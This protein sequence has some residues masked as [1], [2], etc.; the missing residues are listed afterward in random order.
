MGTAFGLGWPGSFAGQTTPWGLVPPGGQG[1]GNYSTNPQSFVQPLQQV[2]QSLYNVTYQL[3]QQLQLQT[4]QQYQIQQLL[5]LIPTQL[6][7]LI[8]LLPQQIQ[9]LPQGQLQPF[10]QATPGAPMWPGT[11]A[12][13][14]G[15]FPQFSLFNRPLGGAASSFTSPPFAPGTPAGMAAGAQSPQIGSAPPTEAFGFGTGPLSFAQPPSVLG[16]SV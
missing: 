15:W 4:L 12:P 10:G 8:Q 9:Q 13:A 14:A 7:Q 16:T 3:Q 2:L 5:Q 1:L 11:P 6:Q